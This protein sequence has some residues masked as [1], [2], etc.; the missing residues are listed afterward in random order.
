MAARVLLKSASTP[1]ALKT[2][3]EITPTALNR[4]KQLQPKENHQPPMFKLGLKTKGCNGMA[5]TLDFTDQV[6]KYDELVEKDGVKVVIDSKA[7]MSVIGT[8]M[9][10]QE[11]ELKSEFV[12][13]NPNA[14][15]TCGCGES[16]SL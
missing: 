16:F 9:D 13:I 6:G 10:Y 8:T 4:L 12:F 2:A 11:D 1:R 7:L 3:L 5:Y 15:S 14:K